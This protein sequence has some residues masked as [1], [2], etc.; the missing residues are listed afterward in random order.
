MI[1]STE[2]LNEL[3]HLDTELLLA[4]NGMRLPFLDSFMWLVSGKIIWAPLYAALLYTIIR[5]YNWR[6]VLG[7]LA[8]IVVIILFTDCFTSQVVRPFFARMRP[9]NPDNPLCQFIHVVDGYRGGS[10]GFPSAHSSNCWGLAFF[11]TFLFRSSWL[12]RFMWIWAV[13]VCYSRLYLGVH[14]PGD[15]LM[16]MFMGAIGAGA[17][18]YLF[19]RISGH[20]S[21]EKPRHGTIPVWT[22]TAIFGIILLVSFFYRI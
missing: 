16:G 11:I 14:Y 3:K 6:I 15:I 12:A 2:L 21:V 19:S 10:Y 17:V 18:F 1:L 9:S 5:N 7:C 8:T 4:V 20:K 13:L 22:G